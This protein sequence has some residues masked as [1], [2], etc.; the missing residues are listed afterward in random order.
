MSEWETLKAAA[1]IME[2]EGYP[3]A[4]NARR[5]GVVLQ[6]RAGQDERDE[7]LAKARY[8]VSRKHSRLPVPEWGY[9]TGPRVKYLEMARAAREHIS[10]EGFAP[11]GHVTRPEDHEPLTV[12]P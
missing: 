10:A 11:G 7:E 9:S 4:G 8:D 1:E 12:E 5:L 6:F 2:R 3:G